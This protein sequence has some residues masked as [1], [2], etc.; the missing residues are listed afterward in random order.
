MGKFDNKY[1]YWIFI[2]SFKCGEVGLERYYWNCKIKLIFEV[3]SG[4]IKLG[5]IG[6]D[7]ECWLFIIVKELWV[8]FVYG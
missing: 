3:I 6:V 4:I 8:F 7:K 2:C 5:L 1:I